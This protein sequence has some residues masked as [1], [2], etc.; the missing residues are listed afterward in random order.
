VPAGKWASL[1]VGAGTS[2]EDGATAKDLL[3]MIVAFN[4]GM[5]TV[6]ASAVTRRAEKMRQCVDVRAAAAHSDSTNVSDIIEQCIPREHPVSALASGNVVDWNAA[7]L[8]ERV[9]YANTLVKFIFANAG[10]AEA[11]ETG[12]ANVLA[13]YFTICLSNKAAKYIEARKFSKTIATI[14]DS[15]QSDWTPGANVL[16]RQQLAE[17]EGS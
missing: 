12:E 13:M 6:P 3:I 14:A 16:V 17:A 8:D 15:C 9:A 10:A 1:Q 11:S 7:N 2:S 5:G 4:R